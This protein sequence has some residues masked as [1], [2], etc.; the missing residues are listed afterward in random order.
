MCGVTREQ[1]TTC[2]V[3]LG[4]QLYRLC[5]LLLRHGDVGCH[6]QAAGLGQS[7]TG[8]TDHRWWSLSSLSITLSH[9]RSSA[10]SVLTLTVT[11]TATLSQPGSGHSTVR[12]HS[13]RHLCP[14]IGHSDP[15]SPLIGRPPVTAQLQPA[16]SISPPST[17][18]LSVTVR[19]LSLSL[20]PPTVII[21]IRLYLAPSVT[22]GNR[23]DRNY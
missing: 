22:D 14:L 7:H 8:H 20:W 15:S 6:G 17:A 12:S 21:R 9:C 18:V 10:L 1:L 19:P 16:A 23:A 2:A 3:L 13:P 4:G 5:P 11:V